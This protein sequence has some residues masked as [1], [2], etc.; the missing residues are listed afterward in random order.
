[1][2]TPL[3]LNATASSGLAVSYAS[4]TTSICTVSGS[5]ASFVAAGT[6]T[7][8][9][10]QTGNATYA[11]A[12]PVSQSFPVQTASTTGGTTTVSL[13]SAAN[14]YGIFNNGSTVTNGGLDT[15]S[16][17][18]SANL[19]G[20]SL[21]FQ[22]IPYAL[23]A[24][25]TANVASASTITLPAGS[26]SALNF[27]GTAIYG[28]VTSQTFTV[29]YTDGTTSTF[30]QS[31]SDW[32]LPQ[33]Y[34]GESVASTMAYRLTSTGAQATG[35][36]WYLYSYSFAIN[37]AKTVKS[38]TLPNSRSVVVLAVTL[39]GAPTAQTITFNP[40]PSQVVGKSLTVSATASSGLPVSF[41][42]VPNGNCSIS[43]NTV[44]FLNVGNCGVV[45]TQAGNSAYAAA[46]A[47]GQVIVV[48]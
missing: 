18:Y 48:N 39:S 2:G 38:F 4:S 33:G 11:A 29:T 23:G 40:I 9:A 1:V 43:G 32:S 13:G 27:V 35:Q 3:T 22:G 37:S 25:G 5:T 42:V 36:N 20:S 26:Y 45:A 46:P 17:A 16:Y 6:C 8:T 24:A 21:T 31:L 12:T 19:L 47:V 41:V 34:T 30:T 7:I 15:S 44:S 10:S 28:P 14:V